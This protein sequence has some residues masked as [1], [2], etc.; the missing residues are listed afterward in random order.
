MPPMNT[1]KAIFLLILLGFI[2]GSGYTFAKY[3][4]SNEVPPLGYAFWQALGPALLLSL[5]S[6]FNKNSPLFR[7]K[8]WLYFFLCGLVGIA[9]PNTNMYFIAQHIPSGLLAVLVNTVPL[10]VYPLALMSKQERLD[11]WRALALILGLS[12]IMLI[13]GFQLTGLVSHWTL[14]ALVSPCCFALCSLFISSKQPKELET[15]PAASGMLLAATLVL[16]PFVVSQHAFYS[17]LGH[18]TP[19]KQVIVLEVLLSTAGY[20]I[21]FSLI[22]LAGPV[23]Y[24]LTGGVVALTGLF[25]GYLIFNEAPSAQQILA[26]ILVISALFLL[27]WRQAKLQ[28]DCAHDK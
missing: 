26:I 13:I 17:L 24:S 2:W 25:W 21:F 5:C 10:F 22:R 4:M 19:A 3:A 28:R 20:L 6:C 8:Y 16:T 11:P 18:F 14:L 23:F 27:S 15:L 12:G 7:P 1:L 9:I